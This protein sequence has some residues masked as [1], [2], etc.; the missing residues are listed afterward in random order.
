MLENP[1]GPKSY[2]R[3]PAFR[4]EDEGGGILLAHPI[5]AVAE[6][7]NPAPWFWLRLRWKTPE[8]PSRGTLDI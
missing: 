8:V 1:P 3:P 4:E 6:A 7:S 2:T 5:R